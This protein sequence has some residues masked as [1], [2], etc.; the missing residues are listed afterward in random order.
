[1]L[2][3]NVWHVGVFPEWVVYG[4]ATKYM[5]ELTIGKHAEKC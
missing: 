1:M 3:R 2:E 5:N 4:I